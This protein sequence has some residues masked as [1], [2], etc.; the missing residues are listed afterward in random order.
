MNKFLIVLFIAT[1]LFSSF[2]CGAQDPSVPPLDELGVKELS[3]EAPSQKNPNRRMR[4]GKTAQS[5]KSRN[6]ILNS[7]VSL[8]PPQPT[9]QQIET[10]AIFDQ[11]YINIQE[12]YWPGLNGYVSREP[13]GPQFPIY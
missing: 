5:V 10:K 4:R 12:G 11:N 1:A 9:D 6:K 8:T 13:D 7:T 2:A 3:T